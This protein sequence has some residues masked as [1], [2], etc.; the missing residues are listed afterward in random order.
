MIVRKSLTRLNVLPWE[1][2]GIDQVAPAQKNQSDR[3][4]KPEKRVPKAEQTGEKGESP[5]NERHPSQCCGVSGNT[6][7][8]R[9]ASKDFRRDIA[10]SYDCDATRYRYHDSSEDARPC[11]VVVRLNG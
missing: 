5:E 1:K 8:Q 3:E 10:D 11:I 2:A 9:R 6:L 7:E 4:E